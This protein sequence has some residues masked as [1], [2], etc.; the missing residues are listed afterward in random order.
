MGTWAQP[1]KGVGIM[2]I[3]NG[4]QCMAG[5]AA[6][7]G[8]ALLLAGC[9]GVGGSEGGS[10][11]MYGPGT[12][13]TS[14]A[15]T[16]SSAPLDLGVAT[17]KL[18][19]VVVDSKG[20]TLYYFTNDHQGTDTSACTAQCLTTWP[21]AT[22]LNKEPV[23]EGVTGQVGTIQSPE[24]S[25]QLTLNGMPLYTFAQDAQPGDTAGQ[26]MGGVWYAVAPDGTMI[27]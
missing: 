2:S 16:E 13:S 19:E 14:E 22:T 5:V 27:K 24:G 23:V 7:F 25:L 18:G 8:V 17:T 12:V 6:V 11:G 10:G 15:P 21:I 26:G 1:A 3:N 9:S 20:M 4:T